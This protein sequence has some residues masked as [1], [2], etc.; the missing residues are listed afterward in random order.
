MKG[1]DGYS[2]KNHGFRRDIALKGWTGGPLVGGK[3][4]KKKDC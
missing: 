2:Q 4:A 3:S 1:L